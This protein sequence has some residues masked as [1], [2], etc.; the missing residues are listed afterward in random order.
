MD[1]E[2]PG[3][4]GSS[5]NSDDIDGGSAV[6]KIVPNLWVVIFLLY[7]V[8]LGDKESFDKEQIGVMEPFPETKC[9]FT[10]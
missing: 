10:S 7:I 1:L 4:G 5:N 8:K 6:A 9:Q 2:L 3:S